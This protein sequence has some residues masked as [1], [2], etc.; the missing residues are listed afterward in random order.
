MIVVLTGWSHVHVGRQYGLGR[1]RVLTIVQRA[2]RK[3]PADRAHDMST[4][5]S[6]KR[7]TK[8]SAKLPAGLK[9]AKTG[10]AVQD[11]V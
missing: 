2:C 11:D 8:R 4:T 7:C 6:T 10:G 5:K 9:R 1:Q 3:P